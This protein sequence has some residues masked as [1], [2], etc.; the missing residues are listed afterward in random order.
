VA[1]LDAGVRR[2]D[3]ALGGLGGC[4]FA[5]GASGNITTEDTVHLFDRLGINSG[6]DLAALLEVRRQL[7][8]WLPDEKLEGKLFAAGPADR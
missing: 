8:Q 1:A 3:S 6:I 5:P 4:P 7:A 2:F